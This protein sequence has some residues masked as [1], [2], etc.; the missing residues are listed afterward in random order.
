MTCEHDEMVGCPGED[1]QPAMEIRVWSPG[2]KLH[3]RE[4]ISMELV[5]EA[6]GMEKTTM[7][8]A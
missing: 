7:R 5:V 4:V 1:V 2:E 8:R 3:Y 6:K